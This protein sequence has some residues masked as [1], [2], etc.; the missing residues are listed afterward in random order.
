MSQNPSR[1]KWIA[2]IAARLKQ[3]RK[4]A[5][6]SQK[7]M[8]DALGVS[9]AAYAKYENRSGSALPAYLVP[10]ACERLGM[11]SWFLLTGRF[12]EPN[13]G[14]APEPAGNRPLRARK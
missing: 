2:G 3:S 6:L 8:A 5:G 4:D 13:R 7:E 12:H 10:L 14:H 9:E 1:A 11:D